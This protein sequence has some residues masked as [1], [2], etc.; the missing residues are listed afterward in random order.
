M[1]L[2]GKNAQKVYNQLEIWEKR[3]K[4]ISHKKGPSPSPLLQRMHIAEIGTSPQIVQEE[5]IQ[6]R[7]SFIDN[8]FYFPIKRI[9]YL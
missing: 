3:R 6:H 4:P 1:T 5:Y 7:S 8:L 2:K 9:Y